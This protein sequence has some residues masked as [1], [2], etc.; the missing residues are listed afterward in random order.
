MTVEA[1]SLPTIRLA[2]TGTRTARSASSV[3]WATGVFGW[4][5]LVADAPRR[6]AVRLLELRRVA[7]RVVV[8][9]RALEVLLRAPEVVLRALEVVLLAVDAGLRALEAV[10]RAVP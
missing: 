4:V 8:L 7:L 5:E 10:L 9:L 2:P 3:A 1:T 6:E